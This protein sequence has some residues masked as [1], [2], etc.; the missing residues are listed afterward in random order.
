MW[1]KVGLCHCGRLIHNSLLYECRPQGRGRYSSLTLDVHTMIFGILF[2]FA[3]LSCALINLLLF[4]VFT[5]AKSVPATFVVGWLFLV[6]LCYGINAAVWHGDTSVRSRV[7]CD[8]GRSIIIT[9]PFFQIA[10]LTKWFK[11]TKLLIGVQMAISATAFYLAA[12]IYF[13]VAD[14]DISLGVKSKTWRRRNE[15]MV[16][17][18]APLVFMCF[19]MLF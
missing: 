13:Y 6:N 16:C 9:S 1:P 12:E 2:S 3:S 10:A 4:L 19:R 18:L 11:A 7:Y 14:R 5:K 17:L 8:I 15:A